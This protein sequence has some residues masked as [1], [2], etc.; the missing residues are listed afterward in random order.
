MEDRRKTSDRRKNQTVDAL[1]TWAGFGPVIRLLITVAIIG[2]VLWM[3][4]Q[5]A[6]LILM[7]KLAL[8]G[9]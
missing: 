4:V 6:G 8:T 7:L 2:G 3:A 1:N 5:I 9:S